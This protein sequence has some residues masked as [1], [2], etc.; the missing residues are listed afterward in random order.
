MSYMHW[1]SITVLINLSYATFP[2]KNKLVF[3]V[4]YT[5]TNDYCCYYYNYYYYCYCY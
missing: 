2:L 5:F 1:P 3:I 4:V